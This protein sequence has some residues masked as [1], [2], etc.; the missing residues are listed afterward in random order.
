MRYSKRTFVGFILNSSKQQKKKPEMTEKK[1]KINKSNRS[2]S[3]S[4]FSCV[5]LTE[6]FVVR[7]FFLLLLLFVCFKTTVEIKSST[8]ETNLVL[9]VKYV[10]RIDEDFIQLRV[11]VNTTSISRDTQSNV[12]CEFI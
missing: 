5:R 4:Y 8:N 10:R 9:R 7:F 11:H 2:I 6:P 1:I 12:V 3:L